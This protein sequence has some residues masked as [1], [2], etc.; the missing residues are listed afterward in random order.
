MSAK[1]EDWRIKEDEWKEGEV[2]FLLTLPTARPRTRPPKPVELIFTL[3]GLKEFR[4]RVDKVIEKAEQHPQEIAKRGEVQ[5]KPPTK[6]PKELIRPG[7]TW[8]EGGG[9][10]YAYGATEAHLKGVP[11][12]IG[13][14]HVFKRVTGGIR[15]ARAS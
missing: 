7:L 4:A 2:R 12:E 1:K 8:G 15:P 6:I 3:K 5:K 9:H 11:S 14:V 13:G 10:L